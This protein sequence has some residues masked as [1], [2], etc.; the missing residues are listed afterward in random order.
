MRT[1]AEIMIV[2]VLHSWTLDWRNVVGSIQV[3]LCCQHLWYNLFFLM[4]LLFLLRLC[5]KYFVSQ[6]DLISPNLT[7][8]PTILVYI[9]QSDDMFHNLTLYLR[10]WLCISQFE[11]FEL[12]LSLTLSYLTTSHKVVLYCFDLISHKL[13]FHIT[14]W[15]SQTM[16]E[17]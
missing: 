4:M 14:V 16:T 11:L 2:S 9:P 3:K 7:L 8:L 5:N 6:C 12:S 1:A 17:V 15:L 10:L 13:T